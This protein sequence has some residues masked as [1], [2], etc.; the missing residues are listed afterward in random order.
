MDQQQGR[1]RWLAWEDAERA[2]GGAVA[3]QQA[4]GL[5]D[6]TLLFGNPSRTSVKLSP[7]GSRIS[8]LAPVDGVLNVWVGPAGD[9]DAAQPV[10]HDTKRG[11]RFY[12]WAYTNRHILYPQDEAGNEDW[13][14]FCV[15]LE[16]GEALRLTPQEKVQARIQA[17]SPERP[18]EILVAL[19]NR[20]PALHDLYRLDLTTGEQTLLL[21][22]KEGFSGFVTDD[23]YRVHFALRT[24][25]DGGSE[26]SRY[27]PDG[28]WEPFIRVGREDSLTTYPITLDRQARVLY[29]LDS[30]KRNT[31]AL[32]SI[33][34]AS[35]EELI[36]H[37]DKRADV[38][39]F[40]S[41]PT[42]HTIQAVAT[43]YLRREWVV[44][45]KSIA[46]DM[47]YLAT[48]AA[49]D[50][51]VVD[52]TLDDGTWV[53]AYEQD[54][55]PMA[56]YRYE[57][58]TQQANYLFSNRPAL[59]GM[60]L[61]QMHP[62]VIRSRDG[63]E[64]V[65]YLSLPVGSDSDADGKPDQPLPMVLLVH[66]GPWGRDTW[67]FHPEHQFL[68]NR[69]YAVLSVNFRGSTGL[70]KAFTNA[71]DREWAGKM[72]DD[73]VDA[74]NWAV[75]QGIADPARVAI[76]GGSYGGYATLVGLTFTPD[77]FAC[78]VD[79]VGP[80]SL[81]TLLESIPPYWEPEI[82]L[83]TERVGDFRTDG[84][85]AFLASRSPLTYVER[86][87]VPLL[88]GQGANDPRVKQAES[89]QIVEAMQAKGIPVT[90]LL[91]PDEGH[92]FARPE[93]RLS[94]YAVAEA[95]LA[96]CIGG[97]YAPVGDA[98]ANSSITAKAG[99]GEVPGL[100]ATLT[101]TE[102]PEVHAN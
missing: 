33:D 8:Y 1:L 71:G 53:V 21:E 83:F 92:G 75:A 24:T 97:R 9:P 58:A 95:F 62:V 69:G 27:N 18:T 74:V 26:M 82:A 48:V 76:M 34:M 98:F 6:R 70:G 40:V 44:L 56:F 65:S 2:A 14:V 12:V 46:P 94:F 17:V 73:L 31:S 3:P 78:G 100:E 96:Q 10:T 7:D 87:K 25:Q 91:Y 51:F 80:S 89:N 77:L 22:N 101:G 13:Q 5:L 86:I 43:T 35:G 16:T 52:R 90:Y 19:N 15:D 38:G 28:T 102:K 57:R 84:G 66:G 4:E 93:N 49:G 32:V 61:A 45:D 64:L 50:F 55:G 54:H 67:G 30:R 36:L 85:R 59:E 99:A 29:L 11:I 39:D 63:L 41:H 23:Q 68:A 81:I 88:I 47:A 42:E 79:I 20:D 37:A 72:H 60:A